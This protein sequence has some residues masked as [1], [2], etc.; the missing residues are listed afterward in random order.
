MPVV[1]REH[2]LSGTVADRVDRVETYRVRLRP[3]QATGPH[4]HPGVVS[5]YIGIGRIAFEIDG[6]PMT[7]LAPGSAFHEPPNALIR[8]FDNL[9]HADDPTFIAFY[10]LVGDQPLIEST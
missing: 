2:L 1:A 7:E 5:G 4:R 3:G 10:P 8:R 6:Q 9:S